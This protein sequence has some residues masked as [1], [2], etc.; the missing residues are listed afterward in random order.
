MYSVSTHT[1]QINGWISLTKSRKEFSHT[2]RDYGYQCEFIEK[3]IK[4]DGKIS[5]PDVVLTSDRENHSIIIECKGEGL[6]PDQY[7]RYKLLEKESNVLLQESRFNGAIDKGRYE[8]E[9]CYSSFSDLST[10]SLILSEPSAFVH[11]QKT[12][13]GILLSNLSEFTSDTLRS[14][15]PINMDPDEDI[16]ME[17]YPFDIE[18]PED[19]PEFVSAII[20]SVITTSIQDGVL[21]VEVVL[22]E[23]HPYWN[24]ID[25]KKRDRFIEEA[26]K[27]MVKLEREELMK[28]VENIAE[29][30]TQWKVHHKTA[31]AIQERLDDPEFDE[32]VAEVVNQSTF[33]EDEEDE[34]DD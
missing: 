1:T 32:N 24:H 13:S 7:S 19:Y 5:K 14:A 15:F 18:Q 22:E 31:E 2:L 6:D 11:F 30:E 20:Q 25:Q 33:S 12:T 34:G 21:D 29:S 10:H 3:Q 28:F 26:K 4:F 16:P 27:V 9:V 23:A 8:N 17:Y